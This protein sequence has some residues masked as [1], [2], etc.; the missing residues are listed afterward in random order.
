MKEYK[1]GIYLRLSREDIEENNSIEA[2]RIITTE[3][4]IKNKYNIVEEY[5]DNGYSG[6]LNSRPGLN[7][8]IVDILTNKINMVIVKDISR[9]TRDKIQTGYYTEV[10]FPDNDIR[11]ISVTEMLDSGER[12]EIDDSIILRGIVNQHYVSDISKKIKSVKTNLKRNGEFIEHCCPYGYKKE[13]NDKYK[14]VIDTNVSENVKLIFSMYLQGYSLGKIAK[15]LTSLGIDTA[16]MYKEGKVAINEWRSDSIGRILRDPFYTGQIVI[17]KYVTDFRTKKCVKTPREKWSLVQGKFEPLVSKEDYNLVQ[18]MLDS[19]TP[20]T[21]EKYEY[22]LKGLVY[23]GHCKSRLQYKYRARTKIRDKVLD[24][25]QKTWYY[26]CRMLYRFPSICNRGHTIQE[27]VLNRIVIENLTKRLSKIRIDECTGKVID[28]YKMNDANYK[29][30][31]QYKKRK[32]KLESDVT[33]LYNKKLEGI[34]LEDDFKE[35]YPKLKAEIKEVES[36]TIQLEQICNVN[37]IDE[38]LHKIIVDFKNGKELTND[39]MKMLIK[40]I[41][42]YEDMKIDIEYNV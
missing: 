3:Y 14:V 30:L 13:D 38:K 25:P 42:V 20:K 27:K 26:K 23:C 40:R 22:L 34:I 7:K 17:N 5:I 32:R 39:I 24:E 15:H 11:F 12:Y 10:F 28:D 1:A 18:E 29:L 37:S 6:M 16:K 41:E 9:L 35:Q 33:V 36:K 19:K 31:E 21:K 4:A 8:M 2:Q